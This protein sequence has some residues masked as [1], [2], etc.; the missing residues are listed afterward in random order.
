MRK[1]TVTKT[2][3]AL[4]NLNKEIQVPTRID[5][6][7][8]CRK[9]KISSNLVRAC[10][11]YGCVRRTEHSTYVWSARKPDI[12]MARAVAKNM[13]DDK[14]EYQAKAEARKSNNTESLGFMTRPL[15]ERPKKT[16][17]V[18]TAWE[19]KIGPFRFRIRPVYSR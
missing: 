15:N 4:E 13:Y 7:G 19:G 9:N 16:D 10:M 1:Q 12:L 5:V 8:F 11:N 2:L 3:N 17:P 18:I 14:R 6:S